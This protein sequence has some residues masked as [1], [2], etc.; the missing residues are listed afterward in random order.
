MKPIALIP[1][2]GGSKR[3]FKKNIKVFVD[4][5]IVAYSIEAAQN[6]KL[7]DRVIVSTDDLEIAELS[8]TLGAEVPFL[9]SVKTSDD[10][11]TL[12]DVAIE[13]ILELKKINC[14]VNEICCILPT[15]PFITAEKLIDSYKS[16]KEN[17][18]YSLFPI[19][20][21]SYPIQRSLF[22]DLETK[23]VKMVSP[24][25]LNTRSQDIENRY[26]DAGQ[27]YFVKTDVLL[28][29]KTFF[30]SKSGYV[31]INS[32]EGQDIDDDEDWKIAELKYKMNRNT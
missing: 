19:L 18:Y 8:K 26:H 5:P 13:V 21:Y 15:A 28:L 10:F 23:T 9:R 4:K 6:S 7:F 22:I 12:A 24:K 16:F 25:F 11:A 29:E 1:A 20:R 27:Y 32:M 14:E 31:E 3:I 17:S 30:T 2:R